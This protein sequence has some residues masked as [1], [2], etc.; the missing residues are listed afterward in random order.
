[1]KTLYITRENGFKYPCHDFDTVGNRKSVL[2]QVVRVLLLPPTT[3]YANAVGKSGF[4]ETKSLD[5]KSIRIF[6]W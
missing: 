5:E 2:K 6:A 4:Q 1:M 3:R